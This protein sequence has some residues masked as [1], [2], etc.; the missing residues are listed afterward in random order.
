[1]PKDDARH[2]DGSIRQRDGDQRSAA[3]A[4]ASDAA[5][6]PSLSA[7][8]TQDARDE[9]LFAHQ[10]HLGSPTGFDINI[11]NVWDDYTGAGIHVA[12]IDTGIDPT[13]PDLDDNIDPDSHMNSRTGSTSAT[14]GNPQNGSDNHGT[15]VA[16]VIAA[17]DNNIGVVGVAYGATLVPIYTPLT[18]SAFALNGLI[19]AENFDVVNNSWGYG[20]GGD[21]FYVDFADGVRRSGEDASFQAYGT[22][23]RNT[24]EDG[25][26]GL[27]TIIVFSAGNHFEIGDDVNLSNFTNSRHA[28]TVGATDENGDPAFF[29]TPGAAI[30]ISAPGVDI[31]TTDRPG[32]AGFV[33][34]Q[35]PV[36]LGSSDY[37]EIDGTSFS[38]PIIS[39]V[40]ALMLQANGGLG[41]RDVQEILA[42]SA[43][44]V[45]PDGANWQTNGAANWNGG[46]MTWSYDYGSGLVD[47]HAAVRLAET[48]FL[49]DVFGIGLAD[50]A[51]FTNEATATGTRAPSLAIPDNS[52]VG[53]TSTM[54]I[55]G[56]IVIDHVEIHLDIT[57]TWVGDLVAE[58]ISPAGTSAIIL[59]LPYL[60]TASENDIDFTFSSTFFWGEH[61]AGEW[62]LNVFDFGPNDTG[63]LVDW[64]LTAYGDAIA[65][66][67]T[68]YYT[69][70][71]GSTFVAQDAA[72]RTLSDSGGN[73]TINI[74]AVESDSTVD[75][76]AGSA[77]I[78]GRT[79]TIAAGTV[80]EN[81]IGGDGDDVLAGNGLTNMFHGGRG[82]DTLSGGGGAD[83]LLGGAGG[84]LLEGGADAD[85]LAGGAGD[86]RLDGG[87]GN[88][89][90]DYNDATAGVTVDLG[91][92][93][94]QSVGGGL[95]MDRFTSI[96]AVSG[97]RFADTLTTAAAGGALS[98][99]G[100]DDMLIGRGGADLLR[101]GG[102][103]DTLA[104]GDGNDRLFGDDGDD[105]LDGGGGVN[106][107]RGGAGNDRLM[108]GNGTLDGG[109]GDDA[110]LLV[111]GGGSDTITAAVENGAFVAA[112]TEIGGNLISIEG[113]VLDLGGGNDTAILDSLAGAGVA[114]VAIMGGAGDDVVMGQ[115]AGI[116][117]HLSTGDGDDTLTGGVGDDTL[118]GGQGRDTL[119][120]HLATGGLT[121]D[122][123]I[124]NALQTLGGGF[125]RDRLVLIDDIRGGA[126]GDSL[127]GSAGAN[128]LEG[129]AGS[130]FL[131]GRDG[132][133]L[134]LG[135]SDNDTLSGGAGNARL[136]GGGG[137]D[138]VD[139]AEAG[140]GVTVDLDS[141]LDQ[142][143]GTGQGSDRLISVEHA[144][145][146]EHDD[147]LSS[148]S[149]GS[150]LRGRGGDDTLMGRGGSDILMGGDDDDILDGGGGTDLLHGDAGDDRLIGGIGTFDGGQGI[151]VLDFI[152]SAL[153]VSVDLGSGAIAFSDGGSARAVAIE[154]VV[155]SAFD[156]VLVAHDARALLSG[157]GG[158]D[159]LR[160]GLTDNIS[161]GSGD[162]T[163][164]FNGSDA[165]L[166]LR[167]R[168]DV[169]WTQIEALSM[170]EGE[171]GLLVLKAASVNRLTSG[172]DRLRVEGSSDGVVLLEGDWTLAGDTEIGGVAYRVFQNGDVVVELARELAGGHANLFPAGQGGIRLDALEPGQGISI[173]SANDALTYSS[174]MRLYG[175]PD[176]NGDGLGDLVTSTSAG[177]Y[178]IFGGDVPES[179]VISVESVGGEN[180]FLV[181]PRPSRLDII[182]DL[183]GD[184]F[185]ELVWSQGGQFDTYDETTYERDYAYALQI[186][187]GSL[188]FGPT[189]DPRGQ[190]G[191]GGGQNQG[192]DLGTDDYFGNARFASL[193]DVDGDGFND[194][195][196]GAPGWSDDNDYEG[197][198]FVVFGRPGLLDGPLNLQDLDGSNGFVVNGPY[199]NA[200]FGS[201]F[202]GGGD[203]NGDGFDDILVGRDSGYYAAAP[204]IY[205]VFG[206]DQAFPAHIDVA[207]ITG[208]VGFS[209]RGPGDNNHLSILAPIGDFN[210]DGLDDF[211]VSFSRVTQGGEFLGRPS[212]V[213]FGTQETSDEVLELD[214][215]D[216][217]NGFRVDAPDP[218]AVLSDVAGAG[219]I[220][221]DGFD[222]LLIGQGSAYNS[223][224]IA[225]VL[226][227]RAST[228]ASF[229]LATMASTDG[230]RLLRDDQGA[231]TG[232][233]VLG[234]E[235]FNGDG[236]DDIA[237]MSQYGSSG[238]RAG[239]D[240]TV[241]F[242]GGALG[243]GGAGGG[244]QADTLIGRD[245]DEQI[246]GAEGDD[247]LIGRGGLDNLSGDD[248][249]DTLIGGSGADGL[250]GGAGND[251][252]TGGTGND[253]LTDGA[254]NDLL[255]GGDGDDVLVVRGVLIDS[256]AEG[257]SDTKPTGGAVTV[258]GGAG[259][260]TGTIAAYDLDDTITVSVIPGGL[261]QA[262]DESFNVV[263]L[264]GVETIVIDG[265][266]GND[267]ITIAS[268][269]G[270]D[271]AAGTVL[272]GEGDDIVD[273]SAIGLDVGLDGGAGDD[274]LAAGDGDDAI[275]G[276]DGNDVLEGGAG[277][278][279]LWG[280]AGDDA[281]DGGAGDD[282]LWGSDGD[283]T[284]LGGA[285]KDR[286]DGGGGS[287]WAD[288]SGAVSNLDI[289]LGSVAMR[290]V[291]GGFD[292][293][294]LIAV[295]NVVGGGLHD[296]LYGNDD[297]NTLLGGG[298]SDR[299][300]GGQGDDSL[301]GGDGDDTLR[302][303]AGSD[304]LD[305]GD[306]EDWIDL[307]DGAG[308][309]TLRLDTE[310]A[311]DLGGGLGIDIVR[312]VEHVLGSRH[313]DVVTGNGGD[314][315][316]I[317]RGGA[318]TLDGAGGADLLLGSE[319]GDRLAGGDGEDTLW[320]NGGD[321]T[322]AGGAGNDRLDGGGGS[323]W[324]SFEDATSGVDVKLGRMRDAGG[325]MGTDKLI[326]IENVIGSAFADTL[327]GDDGGNG[328]AGGAGDDV[329][330]GGRG[331]DLLL[332]EDGDDQIRGNADDDTLYG[333][334]GDDTLGGGSGSDRLDGGGGTDWADLSDIAGG[335]SVSL[336]S[337]LAVALAT[338][339]KDKLIS[340]ENVLGSSGDDLLTGDNGANELMGQ[341]GDDS[342]AGSR[343]NDTI[344][345][346]SGRDRLRGNADDDTLLGDDGD[347]RLD[348]GGEND[349][350]VG[351][352]DDD[353]LIGG[354]GNDIFV[355][356]D[357]DG[358]DT[359]TDFEV[360]NDRIDLSGVSAITDF[361]DLMANHTSQIGDDLRIEDG[362]GD[363]IVLLGIAQ[364]EL[365]EADFIF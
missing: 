100:G 48:W 115:A 249:D 279:L 361:A 82:D 191:A 241:V 109:D 208:D 324:V 5:A 252:L 337:G 22:A 318:D 2:H 105:T 195:A 204:E 327:T 254:G 171:D 69:N 295:E 15:A 3:L 148:A 99:S 312:S 106:T 308:G 206:S 164:I 299:L 36:T 70:E 102:D 335:V 287:D 155:G 89:T 240:I 343:G 46:G 91:N 88:D 111:L 120:L 57:H 267:V 72:R 297:A 221:G 114:F 363:R 354:T 124:G 116:D 213:V 21:P 94:F 154:R 67:D 352:R 74:A 216:G 228:G 65:V 265:L 255:D 71:F 139:F 178:V 101:G 52:E 81:V 68:Y 143:M 123:A 122:L 190:E 284:F 119:D 137:D 185:G 328:L 321:D 332:G 167:A 264:E 226:F 349:V 345:G 253:T 131:L 290:E 276:E 17:E 87:A 227:G 117:L 84:D 53:I 311:Q 353:L 278:D 305:G 38:A 243:S 151:D 174:D 222:D 347:D 92:T 26:D 146:S 362:S 334:D 314:N 245:D 34:N 168:L 209:M 288:F 132:D 339:D 104:G 298:G 323:D 159:S 83:L 365:A 246:S 63:R 282:T 90:A 40:S 235:D 250:S 274:T 135:G 78:A 199:Y 157:G 270:S 194:I 350:L 319:G 166:D 262:V 108:L 248:G 346:G 31:A 251:Q 32:S 49:E 356:A 229:D 231:R 56:D 41:A 142:A 25:R 360:G 176:L 338:P 277:T 364:G 301:F 112:G 272:G 175:G 150:I 268:M 189:F 27:G 141:S 294:K 13:H 127:L 160:G 344:S 256:I 107:L 54:T 18:T 198:V 247:L 322:L 230:L 201:T 50:P 307:L 61:S 47:A 219:D 212:Y 217:S 66:D 136:D 86:D 293:V 315:F 259:E 156:D 129:G 303:G 310:L 192:Y 207:E 128:T 296:Y 113:L 291:G 317:G 121:V 320:G 55:A 147:R 11:G 77:Q 97:S 358:R 313:D 242:G 165:T 218:L 145:G 20:G 316:L 73:D 172:G 309:V 118:D 234:L 29:S 19:F 96:E 177:W 258:T 238:L 196:I 93:G 236:V 220:N 16:G 126:H 59:L 329:L 223:D 125:G 181:T 263:T 153:A 183:D 304:T 162:D 138:T 28:I 211:F 341:A 202:R 42:Y 7:S 188:A 233:R 12:V 348:G 302:G 158:N 30:L 336:V 193:G 169:A 161:G 14:S 210:G 232:F 64:T 355:F 286:F 110:V 98:G 4:A 144:S 149:S 197:A 76:A 273:A 186:V 224:G 333:S 133:D 62:T 260:D 359:V 351:G 163:L 179:G 330:A 215:L 33:P 45:H 285:G 200:L 271:M 170:G 173:R 140:A 60:G 257:L 35:D 37:V 300:I 8:L 331:N 184:G 9:P 203:I 269:A 79:L 306:G 23:I 275:V 75:L 182:D 325:G 326:S 281:L 187:P 244:E 280:G 152:G 292:L 239:F 80:I 289:R 340:I 39:A 44:T 130:D 51:T 214:A 180:G 95:G 6:Y 205:V 85:M 58:V 237:I 261:I 10:W 103:N 1:M 283:D 43:R 342:V 24:A 134:L 266:G 357:G 225:V